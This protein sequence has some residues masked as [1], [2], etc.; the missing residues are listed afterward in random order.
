ML[1]PAVGEE[2]TPLV[3]VP[4]STATVAG[5]SFDQVANSS[6]LRQPSISE[7]RLSPGLRLTKTNTASGN[8]ACR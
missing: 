1:A 5:R 7:L 4:F 8:S 6:G 3:S 2:E